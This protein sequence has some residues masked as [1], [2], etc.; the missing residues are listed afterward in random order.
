MHPVSPLRAV[1]VSL[2]QGKVQVGEPSYGPLEPCR[3]LLTPTNSTNFPSSLL[4]LCYDTVVVG[5]RLGGS[6]VAGIL[7]K[8]SHK[9]IIVEKGHYYHCSKLSLLE[10]PTIIEKYKGEQRRSG[11]I[12]LGKVGRGVDPGMI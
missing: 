8:A 4:T 6:L 12:R 5:S 11:E 1:L 10:G 9:V 3:D 2:A 7:A